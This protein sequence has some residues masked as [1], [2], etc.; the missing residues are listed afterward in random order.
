[1]DAELKRKWVEA[2][3]SGTYH[4]AVGFLRNEDRFCCLGVLC[5]I[6]GLRISSH[7]NNSVFHESGEYTV[8]YEAIT[9][10]LDGFNYY[11]LAERNDGS[12]KHH[13]HTFHEI[14]DYIDA[15]L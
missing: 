15:N 11:E 8:G 6:A 7:D 2:L 1:M 10:L 9:K 3:R 12:N 5:Q 4:Q 14:A 13:R